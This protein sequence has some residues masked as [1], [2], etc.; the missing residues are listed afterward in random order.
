VTHTRSRS[1][2]KPTA[3]NAAEDTE[4]T[5][6]AQQEVALVTGSNGLIG[7]AVTQRLA[8]RYRIVGFA[9]HLPSDA[10]SER[11]PTVMSVPLDLTSDDS[12]GEALAEVRQRC[13]THIASV[14][15]LAAYYDFSGEPS[16]L[17]EE[18]TV[19]GT[20]RLLRRLQDFDVEQFTFSS[21]M[22]VY[23][24]CE[25]GQRIAEDWP[26]EPK[27]DYPQSKVRTEAVIRAERGRVPCVLLRIAGVY[28]DQCHSIP[29]A[30]Q[31]Q[32]IYERQLVSHVF[33][34]DISH[35]QA[36][37][38]LDDVVDL[39]ERVV[40]R[41]QEL[42]EDLLLLVGEPVTLSYDEL[43]RT[44]GQLL[45]G[46]DWETRQIP[47]ELAKAGAWLE[48]E[49][50]LGEKPFIKPWMIDL[51]DDHYALDISRARTLLEWEPRHRLRDTLPLMVRALQADPEGWYREHQLRLRPHRAQSG[52]APAS[53]PSPAS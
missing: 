18:L 11:L 35:G 9:H 52:P 8:E 1:R 32:R 6:E 7:R 31:I 19:R 27:W 21:T 16:P 14:I 23:A 48:E 12:V 39:Y 36:F 40:R 33:P 28:D 29:L 17:Y 53:Q 24:P 42:P 2:V 20:E 44:L 25:P 41:R 26:V 45:H 50:P 22:L 47:K 37:V 43:Q 38:H 15:H 5:V 30:H 46:E 10:A 4:D 3:R 34:G 49:W 51:A 13:G